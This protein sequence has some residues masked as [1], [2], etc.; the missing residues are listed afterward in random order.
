M[1]MNQL[2]RPERDVIDA[3]EEASCWMRRPDG[4]GAE[5]MDQ[6]GREWQYIE[7]AITATEKAMDDALWDGAMDLAERYKRELEGLVRSRDMGQ[8]YVTNW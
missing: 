4:L 5:W 6:Y 1:V 2:Y 7:D 8:E 3:I